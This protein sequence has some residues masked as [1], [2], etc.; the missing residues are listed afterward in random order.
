V[1]AEEGAHRSNFNRSVCWLPYQSQ[2]VGG[3]WGRAAAG[4]ID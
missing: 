3:K 2:K 1:A 4:V